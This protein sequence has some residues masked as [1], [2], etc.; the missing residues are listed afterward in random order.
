ML[1][2]QSEVG[3]EAQTDCQLK[4]GGNKAARKSFSNTDVSTDYMEPIN[5]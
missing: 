4:L 1:N 5:I 3:K 2:K